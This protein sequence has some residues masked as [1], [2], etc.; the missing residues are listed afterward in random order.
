VIVL[1]AEPAGDG[2]LSETK[3]G[4]ERPYSLTDMIGAAPSGRTAEEIDRDLR[5]LRDEWD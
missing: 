3:T 2:A 5:A 1:L 4:P